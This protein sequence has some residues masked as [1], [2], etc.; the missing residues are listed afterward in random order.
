MN[1]FK[2]FQADVIDIL[3]EMVKD[4]FIPANLD[5]SRVAVE[6][7]RDISHG[8]MATNAALVLSK[9]AKRNPRE[10]GEEL[11]KRLL[12]NDNV[13][14]I[15]VA[16]PG[17][18]NFRL[19]KNYWAEHLK[20]ILS[21]G[22][23][24]GDCKLG[25]K[26]KINVEY[27][28]TN[29]TGPIHVGHTRGAV[30]GDSLCNLLEKADFDVTREYYT[31]DGGAQIDVLAKSA[32]I[33]YRQLLGEEEL[34]IP[35]GLYPGEYLIPVAEGLKAEHGT[36]LKDMPEEEW[37]PI[38]RKFAVTQ[39]MELI[40]EDLKL[41]GIEHDVFTSE[42]KLSDDGLVDKAF[43]R[44]T[45]LDLVYQGTLPPPKSSNIDLATWEAKE[46]TLLKASEFGDDSDRPLKKSNGEWAYIT[47]DIAYHFDKF[48]RGYKT[49][50]DIVGTDHD[51]WVKRIK[52]GTRAVTG[53]KAQ[54]YPIMV[55][56]VNLLMDGEPY[57]MSKRAG[58]FVTMRD[59]VEEV[60]AGVVRFI[61][62]TRRND[63][64][65]DFDFK[66][67]VEQSKDNP[68]FYVQYAHARCCSV[69]RNA[70]EHFKDE[71]LQNKNLLKANF[72]RLNSEDEV[73]LIRLMSSYP[74]LIESAA[75]SHEPH[76]VA[77]YL[78]E[79]AA[80]LHSFWNKGK[81]NEDL[82]FIIDGDNELSLAR[83]A[84]VRSVATVLSSGLNILGVTALEEMR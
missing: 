45:E 51:G 12:A 6:P 75:E 44:L 48:E 28:S 78:Q 84:L 63:Q 4:E 25:N 17:F 68:V 35:E 13:D 43:A 65:I 67:V 34:K 39:M 9:Q 52:A 59:V 64:V 40:R 71:E 55:S 79:L 26:E 7:P 24:Y 69:L 31:N 18:V 77:F 72:K 16:G 41:L 80:G 81:D 15:D 56:I 57:K 73:E 33:R 23:N 46:L 38:I 20:E 58:T 54:I 8:D 27:V 11:G 83:M 14:S 82:R 30:F 50:I 5:Y 66:K 60:G 2:K 29:P 62:L 36:K 37:L 61:M 70:S 32:F 1:I 19:D 3:D 76:R 74:R 53:D 49:L 47:P 42:Q 10:I 22:V 21:L